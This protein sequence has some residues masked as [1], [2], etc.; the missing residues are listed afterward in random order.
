MKKL[1]S[2]DP[3]LKKKTYFTHEVGEHG[4]VTEQD[5]SPV[6]DQAKQ[7]ESL[8]RPG[9]MIGNTQRHQQKVA[10]IPTAVYFDLLKKYG[11]PKNNPKPWK[12]WLNDPDNKYFRTTGGSV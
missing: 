10:E 4:I 8:W 6:L 12:K 5:V 11:Q 9:Q 1:L 2:K 3:I 7:K